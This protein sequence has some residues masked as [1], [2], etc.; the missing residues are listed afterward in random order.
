LIARAAFF[1][2]LVSLAP[3]QVVFVCE[4]G[5]AKSVIAAGHF[6]RIAA[7]RKLSLRAISRGTTPDATIPETIRS[8]MLADKLDVSA[9]K[10][11]LFSSADVKGAT[12]IVTLACELPSE[13]RVPPAKLER[14]NDIPPVGNGYEAARRAIVDHIEQLLKTIVPAAH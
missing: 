12:R 5:S 7:E 11:Q 13:A 4:H 1:L 8:G 3:A 9:W 14:W 10:P 2:A 6:N